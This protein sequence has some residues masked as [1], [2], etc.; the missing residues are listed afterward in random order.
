M[1]AHLTSP[2][3][4]PDRPI[5]CVTFDGAHRAAGLVA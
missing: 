4:N 5:D 1:G 3:E 2:G